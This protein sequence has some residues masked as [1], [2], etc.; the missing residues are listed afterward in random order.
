MWFK[1]FKNKAF[2]DHLRKRAIVET[3]QSTSGNISKN[4]ELTKHR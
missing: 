4:E 3:R 2:Y 1:V